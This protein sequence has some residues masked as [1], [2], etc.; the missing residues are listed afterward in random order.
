MTVRTAEVNIRQPSLCRA[1]LGTRRVTGV[2]ACAGKKG[3]LENSVGT[4]ATD[5]VAPSLHGEKVIVSNKSS[6][7]VGT[8]ARALT[9]QVF[10]WRAC[11]RLRL[12]SNLPRLGGRAHAAP[13]AD[14]KVT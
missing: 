14:M 8:G 7:G 2:A 4:Y 3:D 9:E 10:I 12:P 11:V 6:H 13:I 5:D 1:N